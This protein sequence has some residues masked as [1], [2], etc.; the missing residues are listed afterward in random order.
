MG[1]LR[2]IGAPGRADSNLHDGDFHGWLKKKTIR[3]AGRFQTAPQARRRLSRTS[4][5]CILSVGLGMLAG[6]CGHVRHSFL[7]TGARLGPWS[8][9][10]SALCFFNEA[11]S[12]VHL[13][14]ARCGECS[15]CCSRLWI[16]NSESMLRF[17][18]MK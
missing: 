18:F 1:L 4:S 15:C 8:T 12:A 2:V 10:L 16:S 3:P 11:Q 9:V 5:D 14:F 13:Q 7:F 17:G 6:C